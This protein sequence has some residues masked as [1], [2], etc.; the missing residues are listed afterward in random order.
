MNAKLRALMLIAG[1]TVT[2][3]SLSCKEEEQEEFGFTCIELEV[4]ESVEGDP[5]AGTFAIEVTMFYE[6]C[7]IDYYEKKHPEMRA[8][9]P[10]EDGGAVFAEWKERLCNEDVERRLDCKIASFEQN[11]NSGGVMPLYNMTI[12][13]ED[14]QPDQI[15]GKR[16][17]WGPGPLEAYA[18]CDAGQKPF[19][20]LTALP[21]IVGLDGGGSI[22]WSL[23][24]FGA[25]PRGLIQSTGSGCLQVPITN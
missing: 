25:T 6:P 24:S 18:E 12:R 2:G 16:I 9:G 22:L 1:C 17:L 8:D 23:Q 19:V 21:D 15:R 13:Y 3:L 4:G 11:L 20:K 7:L 10:A 5:F 14:L